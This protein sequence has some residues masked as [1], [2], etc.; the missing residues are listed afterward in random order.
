MV[1][2]LSELRDDIKELLKATSSISAKVGMYAEALEKHTE[3]D[4]AQFAKLTEAVQEIKIEKKV[5][6]KLGRI[7]GAWAG[8]FVLAVV[9]A[10]RSF[11]SS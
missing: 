1:A 8:G 7:H 5:A 2:E 3:Q 10:C 9:E 6:S 11:F 4:T